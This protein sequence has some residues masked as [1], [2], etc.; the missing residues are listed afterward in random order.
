MS[1][2]PQEADLNS[3]YLDYKWKAMITVALA[4][5]MGT[6]DGS[7]TNISFPILTKVFGVSVTTVVWVSLAYI[8]TS[9]SLML[10]L[11]R[12]GDQ[13][14]R[15]KIFIGGIMIFT[16]GLVLCSISQNII[17]LIF[18]RVIQAVGS[19]MAMSCG[20][21]IITEAFPEQ[22]R[23][24]GLGFLAVSVSAGLI[25]GPVLGGL[26]LDW[27]HWRS[28]YY[29]RIPFG[30]IVLLMGVFFLNV[31]K[32]RGGKVSFDFL[33]MIFS[34]AGLAA[35]MVGINQLSRY[36]AKSVV[37]PALMALGVL[38]LFIFVLVEK[39]AV[40][41]IVDLTL[42]KNRVFSSALGGLMVMFL[43][44]SVYILLMPFYL[45]KAVGMAP[46]KAGVLMT[47]V[48][49]I[50]IIVGPISGWLSDRF[51]QVWFATLGAFLTVLSFWMMVGF[52]L[53]SGV[54]DIAP[55]LAIAG[56][57]MGMFQSPNHSS[58]MGAVRK[59]RLGTAS[60]MISTFRQV[61]ISLGMAMAGTIYSIQMVHH[62]QV[63]IRQGVA[64][65]EAGRRAIALSFSDSFFASTI[66]MSTVVI[67][68][69]LTWQDRKTTEAV[70]G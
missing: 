44:Y 59:D 29:V 64:T 7:I 51:G 46:S 1:T 16:L 53:N 45:L 27:L 38:S 4:T 33:G 9:T 67:L 5:M 34:S 39:R 41:P 15:K 70:A 22:E 25:S 36:G 2:K 37:F 48:S 58:I 13:L 11:G 52:D 23:G 3:G 57:G 6:M 32:K 55:A 31:D 47:V 66:A 54:M 56:L 26:L 60:A 50:A 68:A 28:I 30:L 8:L 65:L 43:T 61:G 40:D 17:Q 10:I 21:A 62:Q 35:L 12:A 24:L 18:F 19:A 69:A 42:F 14:G 49:M 20:S 63:L